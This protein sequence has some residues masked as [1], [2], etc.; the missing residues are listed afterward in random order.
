MRAPFRFRGLVFKDRHRRIAAVD[1]DHAAAGVC[2]GAAQVDAGHRGSRRKPPVPHVLRQAI[3]LENVS[4]RQ[5][6]LLFDVRRS[7]HLG[8]EVGD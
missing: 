6:D 4:A 7:E 5:A 2:A 1:R 8:V 3:A